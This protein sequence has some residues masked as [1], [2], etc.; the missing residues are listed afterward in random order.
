MKLKRLSVLLLCSALLLAFSV[1]A[2]AA[3]DGDSLQLSL[4]R[5]FGYGGFTKIQGDFTLKISSPPSGLKEVSF[6]ID[7]EL[8]AED[9]SPPFQAKFRTADFQPGEHRLTASGILD[10]GRL[11]DSNAITKSFLSS[12][13]AWSETTGILVPLLVGIGAL[14]LLG[15]GVPLLMS[16]KKEFVLGQYGAAGGAVCPRCGLPFSRSMM[17][18]NLLVGKLARCP[19][20]GKVSVLARASAPRLEE[21]ERKY[22]DTQG[23][24]TL[25]IKEEDRRKLLDD[26]RFEG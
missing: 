23:T 25:R 10:G 8:L 2:A 17:S 7:G 9:D 16:R 21:A 1:T 4:V 26:S 3:Q 20:C 6:F 22:A 24:A 13:Q 15:L 19:H 12:D 14:T 11:L 18:P 5:N